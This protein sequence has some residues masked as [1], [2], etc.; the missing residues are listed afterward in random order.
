MQSYC[1]ELVVLDRQLADSDSWLAYL[2][3][4]CC[5]LKNKAYSTIFLSLGGPD[6]LKLSLLVLIGLEGFAGHCNSEV[7]LVRETADNSA[8]YRVLEYYF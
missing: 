7:D 6:S 1:P 5:S 4:R 8:V 3:L 2:A